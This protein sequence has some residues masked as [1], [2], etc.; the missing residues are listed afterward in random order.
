MRTLIATT[1]FLALTATAGADECI[2]TSNKVFEE[3]SQ[4]SGRGYIPRARHKVVPQVIET[5]VKKEA[6]LSRGSF[7]QVVEE[8]RPELQY[9][10]SRNVV[11]GRKVDGHINL[12][13]V[14]AKTGKVA[15]AKA[16]SSTNDRV[17]EQCLTQTMRGWTFP[18]AHRASEFSIPLEVQEHTSQQA[19]R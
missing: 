14:I 1:M 3:L 17:L 12:S 9:C 5:E 7:D 19:R 15:R 16:V 4:A 10:L 6:Q 8:H 18:S 11:V 2:K 13:L